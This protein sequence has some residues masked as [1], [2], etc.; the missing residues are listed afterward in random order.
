MDP[1]TESDRTFLEAFA[2]VAK[3]PYLGYVAGAAL[4]FV[5]SALYASGIENDQP[6]KVLLAGIF[7]GSAFFEIVESYLAY[8][9]FSIFEKMTRGGDRAG[10]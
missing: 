8:R 10:L 3:R 6:G 4:F 9:L 2:T 5:G 1:L 7:Y